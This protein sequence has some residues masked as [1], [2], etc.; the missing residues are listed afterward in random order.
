MTNMHK[1][2]STDQAPAA[3][4]PYSQAI[5]TGRMLFVSGQLGI[6]PKTGEMPED[7]DRQAKL[8]MQN[9]DAILTQAGYSFKDAVKTTILLDDLADFAVV[10]D[11]YGAYFTDHKPA[12][13]CFQA[14]GIPKGGKVEIEL[15]AVKS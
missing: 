15:I 8:A 9:L 3:L 10:N 4:G 12:R 13:A 14:A 2:I 6:D 11:I 5:D 7:F 1:A